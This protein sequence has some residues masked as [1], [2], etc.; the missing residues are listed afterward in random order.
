MIDY[1]QFH[2]LHD[3]DIPVKIILDN[4]FDNSIIISCRTD[5]DG[6]KVLRIVGEEDETI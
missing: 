5:T 6:T 3:G 2:L 1:L 4:G